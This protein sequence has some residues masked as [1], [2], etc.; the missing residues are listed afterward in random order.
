MPVAADAVQRP[1]DSIIYETSTAFLIIKVGSS[2]LIR[3]PPRPMIDLSKNENPTPV[4]S[5]VM[6][7]IGEH[8]GDIQRYPV[9]IGEEAHHAAARCFGVGRHEVALTRGVDGAL[10]ELISHFRNRRFFVVTPGF[11]GFVERLAANG[12]VPTELTLDH[13]FRLTDT[14]MQKLDRNSVV[15]VAS[16][17]NPTG[18]RFSKRELDGLATRCHGLLIDQTYDDFATVPVELPDMR[19]GFFRFRSFSKGYGLAG[20]RIGALIGR[21]DDI[22]RITSRQQYCHIDTLAGQAVIAVSDQTELKKSVASILDRRRTLADDLSKAG[23]AVVTGDGNF[24]LVRHAAASQLAKSLKTAGIL[25]KDTQELGLA[26]H[27]RIS[28]GTD[29]DHAALIAAMGAGSESL[30]NADHDT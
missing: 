25:V 24:I 9:T 23:F 4:S 1:Q 22:G 8:L 21:S 26:G 19:E 5:Q 15:F 2:I 12:I 30:A 3:I 10:D 17:N 6:R 28:V 20:L 13:D 16:P 29:R 18:R 7:A 27:I 14:Q 11:N